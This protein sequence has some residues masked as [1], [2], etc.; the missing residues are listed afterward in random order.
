MIRTSETHPLEIAYVQ[1]AS[2]HGRIGITFCPGKYHP[3]AMTG[4]WHRDMD[5]DVDVI[6]NWGANLV[7]TLVE[8]KELEQLR[9]AGLGDAVR[10]RGMQWLHL[11]IK[12]YHTPDK[13]FEESWVMH[14]P[15][16]RQL[17]RQGLDILVHCKGGLGRAGMVAARL[18]A[19]LG[20]SPEKAI[21][22][23]RA[24]R[25]G[26]IETAHQE[27]VVRRSKAML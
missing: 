20:V 3:N 2:D 24:A 27:D 22:M 26:A 7:L 16:I 4:A 23:V 15:E 25:R 9:V 8:Q 12:D 11:P 5:I 1:A 21:S 14:G 13:W 6:R 19:E 10:H 18:L 17:L